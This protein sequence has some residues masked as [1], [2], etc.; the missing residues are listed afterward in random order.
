VIT[1]AVAL[2][3]AVEELDFAG[4]GEVLSVWA[5]MWPESSEA[6]TCA[7]GLRVL[8]EPNLGMALD[9]DLLVYPGGRGVMRQL[10]D[11]R[12]CQRLRR[13]AAQGTLM[14]SVCTGALVYADAGL[15]DGR[16]AATHWTA[17]EDLAELGRDVDVRSEARFV[18]SGEV[19]RRRRLSRHRHGLA[20]G[21]PPAL[22]RTGTGGKAA[23]PVRPGAAG[24]SDPPSSALVSRPARSAPADPTAHPPAALTCAAARQ[25]RPM[26]AP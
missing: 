10:G 13:L 3:D 4:P 15:L 9:V 2:F 8:P 18:D 5:R 12:V 25:T 22:Q 23:H 20:L 14:T 1:I 24:M 17:A 19:H 6:V 7:E 26:L 16:A 21:R 11:E